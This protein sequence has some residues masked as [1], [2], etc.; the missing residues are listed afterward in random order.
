VNGDKV[1]QVKKNRQGFTLME[2]LVVLVII[3]LLAALVGPSL[4]QRIKPAKQSAA[5]AQISNFSTALDT[6]FVDVGRYPTTQEGLLALR[7][8]PDGVA[9]WNGPYVKKEIPLDPWGNPYQYRA[10]GRNGG[11]D[12][13]SFG[14]DG[15]EGGE[16][17]NKDINSWENQ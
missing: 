14:A 17:E 13:I 15:R 8:K 11:F 5:S 2:L 10:P 1:M 4:Y 9:K 7:K 16:D 6:F 3:G 12:I